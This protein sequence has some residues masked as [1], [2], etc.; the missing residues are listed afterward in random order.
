MKGAVKPLARNPLELA[1]V[2]YK[3]MATVLHTEGK[4]TDVAVEST[5]AGWAGEEMVG[6]TKADIVG[7]SH[8]T[9]LAVA[10]QYWY[11]NPD[12]TGRRKAKAENWTKHL[13]LAIATGWRKPALDGCIALVDN[14]VFPRKSSHGKANCTRMH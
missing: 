11:P 12:V 3:Q 13:S 6:L 8:G 5:V 7:R 2:D 1:K 10:V 14:L 9:P 4:G